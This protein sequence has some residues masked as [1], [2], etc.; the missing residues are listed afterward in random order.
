MAVPR[1]KWPLALDAAGQL[2]T[3]EQDSDE[4]ITQC[5]KALVLT[6]VGDRPDLPDMGV[7]DLTFT[8][9]PIDLE[10]VLPVLEKH[11]PRASVLVSQRPDAVEQLVADLRIEWAATGEADEEDTT[12]DG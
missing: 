1:L 2:A 8:E 6:R 10:D 9:E 12:P 4:D 11:E 7:P 5:L 3:V